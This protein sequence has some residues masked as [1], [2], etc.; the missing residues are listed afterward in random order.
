M[1]ED[2]GVE[3]HSEKLLAVPLSTDDDKS[4]KSRLRTIFIVTT[5]F[6]VACGAGVGLFFEFRPSGGGGGHG[7]KSDK[8]KVSFLG[9]GF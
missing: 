8:V 2:R 7:S 4:S 3:V 9:E 5:C 6:L 1:E